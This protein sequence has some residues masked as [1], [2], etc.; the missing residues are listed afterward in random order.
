MDGKMSR[1]QADIR[2]SGFFLRT[3]RVKSFG[4]SGASGSYVARAFILQGHKTNL[5]SPF[6]PSASEASADEAPFARYIERSVA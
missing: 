3:L 4:S 1:R 2:G 5:N 6:S